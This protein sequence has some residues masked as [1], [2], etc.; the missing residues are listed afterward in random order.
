MSLCLPLHKKKKH[1]TI[2]SAYAP[3]MTN[4]GETKE[5]FYEDLS[6]LIEATPMEDKLVLLGGTSTQE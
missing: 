4:P 1:T 6:R 3:T 5:A 2:I